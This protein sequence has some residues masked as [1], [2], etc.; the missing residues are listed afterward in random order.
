LNALCRWSFGEPGHGHNVATPR[1]KKSRTCAHGD[2]GN[3]D[4]A[5]VWEE[6]P[7]AHPEFREMT[8]RQLAK[9]QKARKAEEMG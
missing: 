3:G 1:H 5:G 2:I 7:K 8:R 4:N 9:L 6:T